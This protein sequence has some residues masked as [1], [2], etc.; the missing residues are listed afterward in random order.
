MNTNEEHNLSHQQ[1]RFCDEYL[2]HF[3]AFKAAVNAGYSENTAR[4]G[5]LLH[6]P[7][8]QYYLQDAMRKT[9]SRLQITHDMILSELAKIAFSNMG[10]YYDEYAVLKPM[11]QLTND[12]KAAISQYQIMDAMDDHGQRIGELSKIKLHNK[13]SALDKIARHLGFYGTVEKKVEVAPAVAV[14][15]DEKK[16]VETGALSQESESES[17]VVNG[18]SD[19]VEV[20]AENFENILTISPLLVSGSGG[21]GLV[22]PL[23][24]SGI[25]TL[26]L[27]MTRGEQEC[28]S[29]LAIEADTGLVAKA[30][31]V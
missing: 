31:A 8:V 30:C 15:L 22:K 6:L 26:S 12:E 24:K 10:N 16:S 3:N 25:A 13:M 17:S 14:G 27:A 4:K 19:E 5:E 7:K 2:V 20:S 28:F 11:N 29:A 18:E 9:Q 1:Q 21:L 23:C